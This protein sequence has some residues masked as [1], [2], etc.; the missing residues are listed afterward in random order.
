MDYLQRLDKVDLALDLL[1]FF[2]QKEIS[3]RFAVPNEGS[4]AQLVQSICLTSRGSGVRI[5]QLPQSE[6]IER[7]PLLFGEIAKLA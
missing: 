4:L 6:A 3:S 7:W 5:P 1:Y 2:V